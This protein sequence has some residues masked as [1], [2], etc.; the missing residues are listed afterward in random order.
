VFLGVLAGLEARHAKAILIIAVV[1]AAF[2]GLFGTLGAVPLNPVGIEDPSSQSSRANALIARTTGNESIP[3]LIVLFPTGLK[4]HGSA[5]E[6]AGEANPVLEQL[7]ASLR[8]RKLEKLIG[9]D[10]QVGSM[11][12]ALSSGPSL[13]SRDRSLTYILVQFRGN[14]EREHAE[15]AKHLAGKLDHLP[16]VEVGGA[17]LVTSEANSLI[18]EDTRKAELLAFP[19][20]FLLVLWFFR[21]L[22]AAALPLIVGSS[23]IVM[24][25][26]MVQFAARFLSI[27]SLVLI[28]LSALGFGIAIDYCL[29]IVSR[30]REELALTPNVPE[31]LERTMSTAGRT[32]LFSAVTVA[33]AFA[34]LLVLPQPFFYSMGLAGVLVT[35]FVCLAALTILPALLALL[36]PRVNYLAPAWL[37]RSAHVVAQPVLT[38][39]WYRLAQTVMRRPIT[40]ALAATALMVLIGIPAAGIKL[41][42]PSMSTMPESTSVRKVSDALNNH[43]KIDP[44]RT[45]EIVTVDATSRQLNTYQHALNQLPGTIAVSHPEHLDRSTAALYVTPTASALSEGAQ[46]LVRSIR[47]IP[48]PFQTSVTGAT[49]IFIDLKT[50][51]SDHLLMAALLVALTTCLSIFLLTGSVV[52]PPKMLLMNT[53]TA[54]AT[55]GALVLVFQDGFL[56]SLMGYPNPGSIEITQPAVLIAIIFGISTDYGV[57][58]IDRIREV[59]DSGASN[60]QAIANGLE[61]TGRIT[62]TAAL[63]LCVALG[64]LITSRIVAMRELSFGV[65]VALI[66]DA[67]VVRALLVP[68]LMYLLGELNWWSPSFLRHLHAR[69][70]HRQPLP[71]EQ[72]DSP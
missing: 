15:A 51:I 45:A 8:I 23:A 49:A 11:R 4:A 56:D 62:T 34:S 71:V 68:A 33:A 37:Q 19:V 20:L 1:V 72:P 63:L 24:T 27:S 46:H 42:M 7:S 26:A 55:T 69:I 29:L 18:I 31:A 61:R 36:G 16:G 38:G 48:T 3:G 13:V 53:L 10:H 2:A 28:I 50:S 65:V 57:F 32:V 12:S 22:V 5:H 67:T 47:A 44:D 25:Q 41:T 58:L 43:F 39:R 66:L 6:H 9:A 52:L 30:F 21:G 54:A 35:A 64:A 60:E 40:V 70:W 59:H 14:S 17:D